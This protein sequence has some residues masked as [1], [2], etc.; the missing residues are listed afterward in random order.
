MASSPVFRLPSTQISR[1]P[2][3]CAWDRNNTSRAPTG[4]SLYDGA[5]VTA[6]T[7]FHA[8][9]R[10]DTPRRHGSAQAG[11]TQRS[12]PAMLLRSTTTSTGC[13]ASSDVSERHGADDEC[14]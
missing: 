1:C 7:N 9:G 2:V 8:A 3:G 4:M 11:V 12:K 5:A 14:K 6:L 10:A 13:S